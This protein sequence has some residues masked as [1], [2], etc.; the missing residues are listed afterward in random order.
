MK[1]LCSVRPGKSGREWSL[2][3]NFQLDKIA[4]KSFD[5]S[6]DDEMRWDELVA[7]YIRRYRR[8]PSIH[9]LVGDL[10]ELPGSSLFASNLGMDC[11]CIATLCIFRTPCRACGQFWMKQMPYYTAPCDRYCSSGY[12][13]LWLQNIW[14]LNQGLD[15]NFFQGYKIVHSRKD[16]FWD[17]DSYF[18]GSMLEKG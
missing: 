17:K 5:S 8:F 10:Q 4:V 2:S 18:E 3:S 13:K 7:I 1:W 14:R 9:N 15:W 16:P 6:D 11:L 12:G